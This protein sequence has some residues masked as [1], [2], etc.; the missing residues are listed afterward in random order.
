MSKENRERPLAGGGKG[1]YS[2]DDMAMRIRAVSD[3]VFKYIFGTEESTELLKAFVNAVLIDADYQPIEEL[4]VVNPFNAKSYLDDKVSII[5]TRAK[6]SRGNIYNVEVQIRSQGDFQER[7]LYYWASAYSG[8][9]PE[10]HE[11]RKLHKV[12]SI[13]ILDFILFPKRIPFHSCFMLRENGRRDQVLSEDCVMHYLECPKLKQEPA[14]EVEQWLYLLLHAG[15]ED[16][17]MQVLIDQN[18]YFKKVM[19]RYKYF[20]SDEQARLAY[21]ARQK[22]LHDQAS[23]LA[24]AK[25]AGWEEGREEGKLEVARNLLA[26]GL[27]AEQVVQA[28]GLSIEEVE[29]LDGSV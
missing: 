24:D 25:D 13:S 4:Q 17:K 18:E 28:T 21:E 19:D 6:D 15:E 11:Y 29:D 26:L 2:E 12:I 3:I 10:G 20:A 8:Q 14:S 16:E 5:D 1:A 27:P 9:L 23:Y 7:S 22:F